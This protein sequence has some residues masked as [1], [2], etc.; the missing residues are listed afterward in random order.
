MTSTPA[1]T[2][3]VVGSGTVSENTENCTPASASGPVSRSSRPELTMYGSV[4]I[5]GRD[6]RRWASASAQ[7]ATLPRPESRRRGERIMAAR[8]TLLGPV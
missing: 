8:V 2:T 5:S 1:A 4:T 7:R 3:A 6:A